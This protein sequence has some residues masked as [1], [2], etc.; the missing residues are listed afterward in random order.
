M[1]NY[2]KSKCYLNKPI[3]KNMLFL[4]CSGLFII[5]KIIINH[6]HLLGKW[7]KKIEVVLE[8]EYTS[9]RK[10]NEPPNHIKQR[11]TM[12]HI[13]KSKKSNM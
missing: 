11:E 12:V 13:A 6:Y 3:N 10:G 2:V 1:H 7:I 4:M 8:M 9:S 5:L